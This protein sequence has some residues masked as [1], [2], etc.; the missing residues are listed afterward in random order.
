MKNKSYWWEC[1]SCHNTFEF[2]EITKSKGIAHFIWYELLPE[3][4]NKDKLVSF[5]KSCKIFSIRITYL[6]PR[7]DEIKIQLLSIVGLKYTN[8]L[9]MM[10]E[11]K[12]AYNNVLQFDFKYLVGR[13]VWGLNKPAVFTQEDLKTIFN[14]FAKINNLDSFP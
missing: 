8:F 11:T 14:R 7:K 6:F 13:S 10:W 4:W 2:S 1:E 12:E 5:C 3:N 9:P